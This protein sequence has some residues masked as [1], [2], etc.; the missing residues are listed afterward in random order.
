MGARRLSKPLASGAV[1]PFSFLFSRARALSRCECGTAYRLRRFVENRYAVPETARKL[2][3]QSSRGWV[4]CPIM[5]PY[6]PSPISLAN[7]NNIVYNNTCE[8]QRVQALAGR[9]GSNI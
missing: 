8:E 7:I 9:S 6:L 2:E 5:P 3:V 1:N 4:S